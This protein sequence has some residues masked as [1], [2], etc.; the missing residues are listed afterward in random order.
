MEDWKIEDDGWRLMAAC[1]RKEAGDWQLWISNQEG[2]PKELFGPY[3]ARSLEI[4]K[5]K[6]KCIRDRPNIPKGN[7]FPTG[8]FW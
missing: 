8:Y 7:A 5:E 6:D 3:T 4:E 1:W 2:P